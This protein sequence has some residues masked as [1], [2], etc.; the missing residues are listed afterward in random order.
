[1]RPKLHVTLLLLFLP[2]FLFSQQDLESNL[3]WE[4]D[5]PL[6]NN[7]SEKIHD[8]TWMPDGN[9]VVVGEVQSKTTGK[10]GL[11]MVINSENREV[12]DRMVIP[13]FK[14]DV[15]KSV[16]YGDYSLFAVGYTN[17]GK[18]KGRNGWVLELEWDDK[19]K[20]LK[21]TTL[22]TNLNDEFSKVLWTDNSTALIAGKS[23]DYDDSV[24]LL[25][26]DG[27]KVDFEKPVG[28]GICKDLIGFE[29]GLNGR[30][31]L[32]GN[33]ISSNEAGRIWWAQIDQYGKEHDLDFIGEGKEETLRN[34]TSTLE[35]NL[36][37]SGDKLVGD[38]DAWMYELYAN[39]KKP[40]KGS[41]DKNADE[42]ATTIFKSPFGNYWTSINSRATG[43]GRYPFV[44]YLFLW[45]ELN[46]KEPIF[47]DTLTF[48]NKAK[49]QAIKLIRTPDGKYIL[50]GNLLRG[51]NDSKSQIHIRAWANES[52]FLSK[53]IGSFQLENSNP[54]WVD[55]KNNDGIIS[56][57]ELGALNFTITNIGSYDVPEGTVKITPLSLVQGLTIPDKDQPLIYLKKDGIGKFTYN[58]KMKASSNLANGVSKFRIE[59]IYKNRT[60]HEFNAKIKSSQ[61]PFQASAIPRQKTRLRLRKPDIIENQGKLDYNSPTQNYELKIGVTA[62]VNRSIKKEDFKTTIN[63]VPLINNKN[64]NSLLSQPIIDGEIAEYIFTLP[65]DKLNIGKNIIEVSLGDDERTSA[66]NVF[67]QPKTPNLHVIAIGSA[68]NLKYAAKD[69][70]DF[71]QMM[72]K[73]A[74]RGF[75]E[76][77][78]IDSFAMASTTEKT[79]LELAIKKFSELNL[80]ENQNLENYIKP[81][82]YVIFFYSGHGI[83]HDRR[84][85]LVPSNFEYGYEKITS[86]DYKENV[87][88]P[89]TEIDA[90]VFVFIDACFSGNA[91]NTP[92]KKELST[93]LIKANRSA[94]GLTTFAS[95]SERQFSYEDKAWEN[96]AFT[97]VLL[98]ALIGKKIKLSNGEKINPDSGIKKDNK[99]VKANDN[100]LV[101]GELVNFLRIRVE[102]LVKTEL[103]KR[104][105]PTIP[106]ENLDKTIHIF[107]LE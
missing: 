92:S 59:V 57:S 15:I 33:T 70:R 56:P 96:G 79:K 82:D 98:E 34:A 86:I 101:L 4:K 65:I 52:D 28:E 6:K 63:G 13:G 27:K 37:M 17:K 1:M 75:F 71:S 60:I 44:H 90:K 7:A 16:V 68:F 51:K 42:Q 61:S 40:I 26:W 104:Q 69:A 66:I 62:D 84:F 2:F 97:Y 20:L 9:L 36:V 91:K 39:T 35:G 53:D 47:K 43:F 85:K 22:G 89:L 83:I 64:Q 5:Y 10:D 3:P 80:E 41:Y 93:A 29:K 48:K 46:A 12:L 18:Q 78:F 81:N 8:I 102:D 45:D 14:D 23:G 88:K 55:R 31:W 38:T 11:I 73:Q 103:G 99:I 77:V 105:T 19:L 100:K 74:G 67:Y 106:L 94:S 32:C 58:F 21:D 24:W 107:T 30:I 54:I 50:A 87:L 49:F 95:C 76:R 72:A 25:N